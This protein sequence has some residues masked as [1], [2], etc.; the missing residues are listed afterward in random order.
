MTYD[1]FLYMFHRHASFLSNK[2]EKIRVK[3][4]HDDQ[5]IAKAILKRA[6][7]GWTKT[8][9]IVLEPKGN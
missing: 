9:N 7:K 3:T 6:K 4:H 2:E 8:T 1:I 5:R